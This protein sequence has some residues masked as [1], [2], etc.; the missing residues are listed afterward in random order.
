MCVAEL[1]SGRSDAKRTLPLD[2]LRILLHN[3]ITI[4]SQIQKDSLGD[5]RALIWCYPFIVQV[6]TT[7]ALRVLNEC[8]V[9]GT[10]DQVFNCGRRHLPSQFLAHE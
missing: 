2:E 3:R 9:D 6:R 1:E 8:T 10:D 4:S 7:V 5:V